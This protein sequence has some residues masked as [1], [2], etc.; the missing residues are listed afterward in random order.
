[1]SENRV[2]T[3]GEM[4]FHQGE[5]PE[6]IYLL[7]S[8]EIEIL[9]TPEEFI[10]LNRNTVVDK[11]VRVC[12][13][14]GK[15]MLLGFSGLLASKY[16]KSARAIA[17]SEIIE[18]P[19]GEEGFKWNVQHDLGGSINMLRQIFNNFMTAHSQLTKAQSLFVRLSQ[20]DDNLS[21]IYNNLSAGS[22]PEFL[23]K[24]SEDNY[25]TF[26]FN[27]GKMPDIITADFILEDHSSIL[28][29]SYSGKSM[30]D[31]IDK[32]YAEI[33]KRLLRLDPQIVAAM[34]RS[35]PGMAVLMFSSIA[36]AVDKMLNFVHDAM[37]RIDQKAKILFNSSD[38]WASFFTKSG[39]KT[40]SAAGRLSQDFFA[41]MSKINTK[42]NGIYLD[43]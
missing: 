29:R 12:T 19:L 38:S 27:K 37:E 35:D 3:K 36:S 42:L 14:K 26:S 15:A 41:N 1:M 10:G 17:E 16:S 6:K 40:W 24:K 23:N 7:Q 39:I 11:G 30:E 22:G 18:Y 31:A 4:L 5:T 25:S 9:F 32:G 13:I 43:A 8:G 2:L 33:L 34:V 21:L 20:I 28:K